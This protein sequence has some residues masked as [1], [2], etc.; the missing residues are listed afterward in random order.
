[1]RYWLLLFFNGSDRLSVSRISQ[2]CEE[3]KRPALDRKSRPIE[4]LMRSSGHCGDLGCCRFGFCDGWLCQHFDAG[5]NLL[6]IEPAHA[7]ENVN[8]R[9]SVGHL[10]FHQK[11]DGWPIRRCDGGSISW[12]SRGFRQ[13]HR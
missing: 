4:A 3:D 2:W 7:S 1:M 5:N 9:V 12:F 10:T 13:V 8:Q 6:W 11:N